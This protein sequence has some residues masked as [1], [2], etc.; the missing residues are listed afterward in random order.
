MDPLKSQDYLRNI[1]SRKTAVTAEAVSI[2]AGAIDTIKNFFINGR[3]IL[4]AGGDDVG[5][6]GDTS[7]VLTSTAFTTMVSQKPDANLARGEYWVN[8]LTGKGRGKKADT[9][10]SATADYN[11]L[12]LVNS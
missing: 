5:G 10:T 12:A 7:L 6:A 8:H 9:S 3:P 1:A 4:N 2:P 11:V